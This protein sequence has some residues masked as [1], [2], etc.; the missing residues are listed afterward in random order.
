VL[1]SKLTADF[2][3]KMNNDL[4]VKAAFDYL[5]ETVGELH[6]TRK[7]LETG[8]IKNVLNRL[9]RIDSVLQCIF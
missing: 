9:R 3:E 1:T 8:N 6:K 4:D 5:Y 2:E 7:T